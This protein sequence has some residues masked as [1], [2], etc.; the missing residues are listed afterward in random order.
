MWPSLTY[1]VNLVSFCI[2]GGAVAFGAL[3][4]EAAQG[5]AGS[6]T[7]DTLWLLMRLHK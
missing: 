7:K 6:E 4:S 2:F 1:K 3:V 5:T